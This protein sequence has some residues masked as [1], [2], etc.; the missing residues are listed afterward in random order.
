MM[1]PFRSFFLKKETK[2]I[3][4]FFSPFLF[5]FFFL[6]C[7]SSF[8]KQDHPTSSLIMKGAWVH[9]NVTQGLEALSL[10]LFTNVL[11]WSTAE[12]HALIGEA[13]KD[14][15]NKRIHSYWPV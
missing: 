12:V 13:K 5:P 10:M 14:M 1:F 11:G 7:I 6:S 15:R 9:E 2:F 4:P 3:F 8:L